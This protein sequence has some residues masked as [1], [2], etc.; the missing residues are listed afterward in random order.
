MTTEADIGVMWPQATEHM[1]PQEA[2]RGKD[3]SLKP[4]MEHSSVDILFSDFWPPEP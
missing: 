4:R 2:G 3:S 1:Q